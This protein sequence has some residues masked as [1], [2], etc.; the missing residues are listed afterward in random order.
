M[1]QHRIPHEA[2]R[3][4]NKHE[5]VGTHQEARV[6]SRVEQAERHVVG[7][8]G[9]IAQAQTVLPEPDAEEGQGE[10]CVHPLEHRPLGCQAILGLHDH[11]S[12]S[13][14]C[15]FA[16]RPDRGRR[17]RRRRRGHGLQRNGGSDV[18]WQLL[19]GVF[20]DRRA[21]LEHE[22]P[23]LRGS[24]TL[25]REQTLVPMRKFRNLLL[26]QRGHGVGA[27]GKA[28]HGAHGG[29]APQLLQ[30]LGRG[31]VVPV[32]GDLQQAV[33][34]VDG[35]ARRR[36]CGGLE[37]LDRKLHVLVECNRDALGR[38]CVAA[39]KH[40][41]AADHRLDFEWLAPHGGRVHELLDVTGEHSGVI[42]NFSGLGQHG[43]CTSTT[44][45]QRLLPWTVQGKG[46]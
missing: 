2:E 32:A 16:C 38:G 37:G 21:P 39:Q 46:L 9:V 20:V 13:S 8:A 41:R 25:R 15:G 19:A 43:C 44:L 35:V 11:S 6:R 14:G 29:V 28:L 42:C 27:H 40:P 7:H 36:G 5:A 12:L 22:A 26:V 31:A 33:W 1:A 4:R 34:E 18:R 30:P 10:H 17:P 24:R 3:D 23:G 45:L